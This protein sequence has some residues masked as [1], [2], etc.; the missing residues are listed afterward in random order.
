MPMELLESMQN[1][2]AGAVYDWDLGA[3]I[4]H[5]DFERVKEADA[6][7]VLPESVHK[8]SVT[9]LVSILQRFGCVTAEFALNP[10]QFGIPNS[11]LPYYFLANSPLGFLGI[12]SINSGR[13]LD[14]IMILPT[15]V[16]HN[17]TTLR[18]LPSLGSQ[19]EC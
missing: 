19:T 18:R 14:Y 2:I 4:V 7:L 12:D 10:L 6:W 16:G 1:R 11:R 17:L 5:K 8:D 15:N 13:V 9:H 3:D